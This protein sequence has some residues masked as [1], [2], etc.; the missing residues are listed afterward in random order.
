MQEFVTEL[1]N[2]TY[3]AEGVDAE[4]LLHDDKLLVDV[5][6]KHKN[7]VVAIRPQ[8]ALEG[9]SHPPFSIKGVEVEHHSRED[10]V[11]GTTIWIDAVEY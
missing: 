6:A 4:N 10:S 2:A 7:S 3:A 1:I 8:C 11:G 5:L 9:C